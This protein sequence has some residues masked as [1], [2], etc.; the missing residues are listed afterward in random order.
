MEK[1]SGEV[2]S[3][4]FSNDENG[5]AILKITPKDSCE[6]I[7]VTGQLAHA[8]PGE[9]IT[10]EGKWTV[11]KNYGRQFEAL[12]FHITPPTHLLGVQRYLESNLIKG[13]G[14][15]TAKRIIAAFGDKTLDVLDN[16][17]DKLLEVE[18]VGLKKLL[19]IKQSWQEHRSLSSLL[20]F[21]QTYEIPPSLAQRIFKKY[22]HESLDILKKNPFQ[23]A[24][25][26]WG[27]GFKTADKIALKLGVDPLSTERLSAG[28]DCILKKL[29]EEGH[30]C[31]PLEKLL[32]M[33]C[34]ALNAPLERIEASLAHLEFEGAVIRQKKD[35]LDWISLR[36][37]YRAEKGICEEIQ[38]LSSHSS[39]L[40]AIEISKAIE[41]VQQKLS[42][43]LAEHQSDAVAACF[44]HKL[45]IITGGPGTGKSTITRAILTIASQLSD[46]ILLAAPT[47]RAAKRLS[48]MARKWA[49]TI[50][51]LLEFNPANQSFKR[52]RYNQLDCQL[53]IIDEMSMVDASL[54]HSLLKAIPNGARAV[55]IGD[56]D[57]LPSVGPG[58]VLSDLIQSSLIHTTRL[59][60][61]F[62]QAAHSRISIN[63]HR[64][65][66]GHFPDTS[67]SHLSDFQFIEADDP[68]EIID[69]IKELVKP[70]DG[71][72]PLFDPFDQSQILAPIKKGMVGIE[73][74]NH[75][76][77]QTLNPQ[78]VTV[79][80]F[81]RS[82][83]PYDKVM[84][85]RNNY[86]KKIYNGDIGRIQE[87]DLEE[88]MMVIDFDGVMIEYEFDELDELIL[89][90]AVSIHKYQG[91]EAPCVII[92]LH[93]SHFILLH[94]N[95]LYTAITRGKKRVYLI[96]SKKALGMA[97]SNTKNQE[98][99]TMLCAMLQDRVTRHIPS[100]IEPS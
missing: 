3:R 94:R 17:A 4:L 68:P 71:S 92:P 91:S 78:A 32:E 22:G 87:I 89:A 81:G 59:T 63:A 5:F 93:T 44:H 46:K 48:Q 28:I 31:C 26:V 42:L 53:I 66:E 8:K 96:G 47:G 52:D 76:L 49:C 40:R 20:I 69:R 79:S 54:M 41:W 39:S 23:V 38:R 51:S 9:S 74:L 77:Q 2:E 62:R 72:L 11:H 7:I 30:L 95:L 99:H 57:Q 1:I 83:R 56:I 75:I 50:H 21:L 18:G 90:Y 33:A 100:T 58:Q 86:T 37:F 67:G 25:E 36:D 84:Q 34:E 60:Q 73:N 65:L 27:I 55:F 80:R 64:L 35:D 6:T 98:R 15:V 70:H 29:S 19:L 85:I 43:S 13:I 24:R 12:V 61:I 10:C 16:H 88:Q 14:P 82:F 97:V 45:S